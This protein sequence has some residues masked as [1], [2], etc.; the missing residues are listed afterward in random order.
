MT[1]QYGQREKIPDSHEYLLV[2]SY[3]SVVEIEMVRLHDKGPELFWIENLCCRGS[4]SDLISF[5]FMIVNHALNGSYSIQHEFVF[6]PML[7]VL[8]FG[9]AAEI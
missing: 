8:C 4:V 1:V 9:R 3:S 2:D 6:Q 5:P 7:S